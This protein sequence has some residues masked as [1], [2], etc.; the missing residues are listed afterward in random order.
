ALL[1]RR[2]ARRHAALAGPPGPRA[3][4]RAL[5]LL[6]PGRR[7]RRPS[8]WTGG[9]VQAGLPDRLRSDDGASEP[10]E[11]VPARPGGGGQ[12][13]TGRRARPVPRRVSNPATLYDE[14]LRVASRVLDARPSGSPAAALRSPA[15]PA[16][17]ARLQR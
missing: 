11:C 12:R 4:G 2:G 7:V 10:K 15:S 14:T 1:G 17:L 6:A 8:R 3:R 13:P 5:P 16:T 9:S